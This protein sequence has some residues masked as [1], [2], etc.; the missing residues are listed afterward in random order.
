MKKETLKEAISLLKQTTEFEVLES[1]KIKV[2][3]LEK[4][5]E[6][7]YSEE[8]MKSFGDWCRNGLLNIEYSIDRLDKHLEQWN[9]FKNK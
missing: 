9:K 6:K 7:S 8:D 5:Q 4:Q 1:F 3:E 2:K